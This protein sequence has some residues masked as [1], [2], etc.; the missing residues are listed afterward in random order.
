[1]T[2]TSTSLMCRRLL[3]LGLGARLGGLAGCSSSRLATPSTSG[4]DTDSKM[5]AVGPDDRYI[6]TPE[7]ENPLITAGRTIKFV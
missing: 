3:Q 6:F 7:T 1:M 5:V 4:E 2:V